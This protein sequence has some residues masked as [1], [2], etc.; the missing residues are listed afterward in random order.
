MPS[1]E[2]ITIGTEILLGEILDTNAQVIARRF[3]DL[4]IDLYRKTTVGDNA[5]RIA[6]AI[7]HSMS[8]CDIILTTGGLGPTV[9]DPTR[10]AIA[11]A[12]GKETIFQP[13]LW[14]QIKDRFQRYGR[15]PT[16][17]NKRQA[18]IP[19]GAIPIENPV[20]TA[21]CFIVE[22]AEN[23]TPID[24]SSTQ[25]KTIIALPG[26]PREMEYILENAIL[27]YLSNRYHLTG[28][29]K[30]R[31][32]H[33]VG[34][35]ESQIDA[36]IGEL[37]TSSNPTVGLAAH[38]GQVDV[39]I[40]AKAESEAKADQLI[41]EVEKVL[42]VL[43]SSWIYGTDQET[44]EEAALQALQKRG[45]SIGTVESGLS[46]NLI[47]RLSIASKNWEKD[48]ISPFRGGKVITKL[49]NLDELSTVTANFR[50]ELQVEVG[51]GV[52]IYQRMEKQD[53]SIV[54]ITPDGHQE[55]LR[56]FGGPPEYGPRW[57]FHH[58]LDI[59]RKI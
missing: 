16:E 7:K 41:S 46:G 24:N 42:R 58:S 14:N 2:I 10:E 21:P 35:G 31:L 57:A 28:I 52:V 59:I 47:R 12:V 38:S 33:T 45:W 32:I 13:D 18:Y 37:E 6:Q 19:E 8:R 4:G 43:L 39:R 27:P 17:N 48:K 30:T 3:R 25:V 1:A 23:Q 34:I 54:L 29:I 22:H 56:P 26:V 49:P 55:F 5:G 53:V 44:L 9:D 50:Q 15:E 40:T 20:G 36:L 11:L 51:L